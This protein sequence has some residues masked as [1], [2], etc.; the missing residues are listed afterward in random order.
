MKKINPLRVL[1]WN[2]AETILSTCFAA[3][4]VTMDGEWLRVSPYGEFPNKAGLQKVT[5]EDGQT[6]VESFNSLSGRLGRGFLGIPIFVGHPDVDPASYPDK[7]RIGRIN[8]LEAREDGVYGLV[9]W[10]SLGKEITQEGY[11]LYDS[12]TWLLRRDGKYI[13]PVELKSVGMTN[14]PQ[15]PNSPWAKNETPNPQDSMDWLLKQLIEAGLCK[16][17]DSQE[18]MQAAISGLI[19]NNAKLQDVMAQKA[20]ADTAATEAANARTAQEQR[21]QAANEALTKTLLDSGI[22]SGRITQ[23]QRAEWEKKFGADI[24]VAANEFIALK[25]VV[26]TKSAVEG[27]GTR[28]A[29]ESTNASEKIVAIN[30]AVKKAALDGGFNLATNEGHQRAWESAKKAK[31][32]LFN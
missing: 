11:Y 32:E 25:P 4:E 16:E 29:G 26:P 28:K 5:K 3:N 27:V 2:T 24:V 19:A 9:A 6:L 7:R 13:R 31:P 10:N 8:Q 23:A 18:A 12:P 22:T 14:M 21:M 17:G 30:E 15:I 20:A 1:A